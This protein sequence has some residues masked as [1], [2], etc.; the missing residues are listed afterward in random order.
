MAIGLDEEERL[1]LMLEIYFLGGE[2]ATLLALFPQSVVTRT[3]SMAKQGACDGRAVVLDEKAMGCQIP[4]IARVLKKMFVRS[5][6][7]WGVI[8]RLSHALLEK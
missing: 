3:G 1:S 6:G 8:V 5:S 7:A 2:Q 4:S